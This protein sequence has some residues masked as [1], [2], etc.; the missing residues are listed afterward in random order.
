MGKKKKIERKGIT[1]SGSF[2]STKHGE[3]EKLI[4]CTEIQQ[5]AAKSLY[6]KNKKNKTI[7]K[8]TKWPENIN[9]NRNLL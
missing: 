7:L 4:S 3:E 6:Y 1:I 5:I 9:R 2:Q 8:D